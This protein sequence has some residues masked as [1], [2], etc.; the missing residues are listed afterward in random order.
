[1]QSPPEE[2]AW[3]LAEISLYLGEPSPLL[4]PAAVLIGLVERDGESRVVLTRRTDHLRHHAGQI[5]FPGGRIEQDDASP[6]D[7]ALREAREEIGL[8]SD[9]VEVLGYLDPFAT[10]SA[11]HVYPVVARIS[12]VFEA[13]PDE[14]EVAEVFETPFEFFLDE[15]NIVQVERSFQGVTRRM[16]EYHWQ[17]YRIWGA[18]AMMM[19]NFRQRLLQAH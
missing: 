13:S 12:S 14:N 3:N 11:Y 8:L 2:S 16:P 9:Q 15:K 19:L 18:T 6:I 7:A 5:S 1:M 10:I 17:N 4:Q